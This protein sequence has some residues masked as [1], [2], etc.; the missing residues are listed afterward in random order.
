MIRGT[1]ILYHRKNSKPLESCVDGISEDSIDQWRRVF[2]VGA[3]ISLLTYVVYQI[4][5][6]AEIQSWNIKLPK[7]DHSDEETEIFPKSNREFNTI[8]EPM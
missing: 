1:P 7:I 5:G 6:T 2:G 3:V 4:F 8:S